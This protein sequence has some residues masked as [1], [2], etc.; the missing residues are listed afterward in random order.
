MA[1]PVCLSAATHARA[2]AGSDLHF[3][4]TTRRFHFSGCESCRSLFIEPMPAEEELAS[5]YPQPYWWNS[6]SGSL[7]ALQGLY[8]RIVLRD[9]IAFIEKAAAC[10]TVRPVRLLD[11][12]CG[13][14][15]LLGLLKGRHFD[16]RGFDA[17][18]EA[19]HIA[20]AESG[21][22]VAVGSNL[23]DVTFAEQ[24]F[25]LVTLFHV[26]EHVPDP[27]GVL[28]EVRRILQPEGRMILQ[29]PN[30]AS[31]QSRLLGARWYALDVPRHVIHYSAR[32]I[33]RLVEDSGFRVRRVQHINLR[34]NAPALASSL[35][36]SLDPVSRRARQRRRDHAESGAVAGLKDGL[37]LAVVAAVT[38][39]A[40]VEALAGAGA[41]V[42]LEAEKA[43]E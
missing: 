21:V 27:R 42:M 20:R 41:T 7:K 13:S 16:V 24:A 34:D 30:V 19:A 2:F 12:G 5:F 22:E 14:G 23:Q 39:F 1:C 8:R 6:S 9:H 15:T 25:D 40:V 37:Y 35:F 32:S 10:L 3:E 43:H 4:T 31:W 33:Q 29:V 17:S 28:Q 38:P 18:S 11:V 26:L 36:P